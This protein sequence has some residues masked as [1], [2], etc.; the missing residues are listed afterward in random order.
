M[1]AGHRYLLKTV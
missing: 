1:A